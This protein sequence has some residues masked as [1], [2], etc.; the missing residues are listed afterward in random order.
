MSERI[1]ALMDGELGADEAAREMALL[2]GSDE[3]RQAWDSYHLIG[4][5]LRGDAYQSY[6]TRVAEHLAVEP[7]VLAP[8]ALRE[9]AQP[10]VRYALSAAAAAAGV[11]LVVW[12][13]SP[14]LNPASQA[15]VASSA[16]SRSQEQVSQVSAAQKKKVENYLFAHQPVMQAANPNIQLVT[17][18]REEQAR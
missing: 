16:P 15:Q 8:K 18:E 9:P 11:A 3:A 6:A 13:A 10:F 14:V 17:D 2:R 5:A 7:T 4:D 1:S 12:T